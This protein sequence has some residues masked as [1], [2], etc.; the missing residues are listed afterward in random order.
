[1]STNERPVAIEQTIHEVAMETAKILFSIHHGADRELTPV[2]IANHL[3][4]GYLD[5]KNALKTAQTIAR[6]QTG[7]K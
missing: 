7:L 5:A 3:W 4:G 1:M 6:E 2:Q